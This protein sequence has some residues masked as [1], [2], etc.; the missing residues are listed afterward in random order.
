MASDLPVLYINKKYRSFTGCY[1]P[2]DTSGINN[3]TVKTRP[4]QA[5]QRNGTSG[6]MG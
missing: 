4:W 2:R 5:G 3:K 6:T 1:G